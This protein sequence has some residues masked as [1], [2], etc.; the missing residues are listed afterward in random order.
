MLPRP[1]GDCP[2]LANVA[3]ARSHRKRAVGRRLVD[4]AADALEGDVAW[5]DWRRA[6]ALSDDVDAVYA[7]VTDDEAVAFALRHMQL[8]GPDAPRLQRRLV[9]AAHAL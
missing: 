5:V 7:R 8:D 6:A 1:E 2:T 4:A 9:R 3:V